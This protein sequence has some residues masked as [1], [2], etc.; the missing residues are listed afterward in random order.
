MVNYLCAD[1]AQSFKEWTENIRPLCNAVQYNPF[2]ALS[3]SSSSTTTT[4]TTTTTTNNNNNNNN[5]RILRT[6]S[7]DIH[8]ARNVCFAPL[9]GCSHSPAS[10]ANDASASASSTLAKY[11][12]EN[13][14]YCLVLFNND[15][16]VASTRLTHC[17]NK[18]HKQQTTLSPTKNPPPPPPPTSAI[19]ISNNNNSN[20]SPPLQP[21]STT[22][23]A[24]KTTST[25]ITSR[26]SIWDESFVFENLPL[27]VNEVKVC[28]YV[29]AK[30]SH[31]SA[32]SLV[33]NLKKI[34]GASGDTAANSSSSSPDNGGSTSATTSESGTGLGSG[35]NGP[36]VSS[37]VKML[38]PTLIG[39]VNIRLDELLNKGLCEAWHK[40]E[41]ANG[42]TSSSSSHSS[43]S[44]CSSDN[45]ACTIRL[46][47]R[48]CQEKIFLD[49]W[50]YAPLGE[51]L[52]SERE[53][54]HLCTLYERVVPSSERG[55]LVHA[56]LRLFIVEHKLVDMLTSFLETEIDGCADLSTLFRSA[57]MATSLM[58]HYMRTRCHTFLHKALQQPLVR[59][60][61]G[62]HHAWHQQQLRAQQQQQQQHTNA[63]ATA[64]QSA[65][66]S[67]LVNSSSLS[68]TTQAKVY[69]ALVTFL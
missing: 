24:S 6:L 40:A 18:S 16:I 7:V 48:Y 65:M 43:S 9:A 1:N 46:K 57:S 67:G 51:Y 3:S 45:H 8:E 32:S 66:T 38:D 49:K 19:Q 37:R 42:S 10:S 5:N 30:P 50:L 58:D 2:V 54:P 12:K 44:A 35:N 52:T 13:L 68:S 47:I 21:T 69:N 64:T 26:D 4:T 62:K 56:M 55:H 36:S 41:P 63:T 31:F 29:I 17:S 53:R 28:L 14:Y 61:S 34:G 60:L 22:S 11:H 20:Q 59:V 25:V 27:D 23:T 39:T 15:A 33:N